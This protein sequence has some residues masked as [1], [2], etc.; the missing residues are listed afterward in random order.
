M[1]ALYASMKGLLPKLSKRA[2]TAVAVAMV[3]VCNEMF[4]ISESAMW[5]LVGIGS[6]LILGYTVRDPGST[7]P[8]K[9]K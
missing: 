9:K 6:S 5:P 1:D 4:G 8:T 3:V 2:W 7:L